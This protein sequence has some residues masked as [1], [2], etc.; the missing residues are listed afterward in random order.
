MILRRS[1]WPRRCSHA[2]SICWEGLGFGRA[3]SCLSNSLPDHS[4][5]VKGAG[6]EP[7]W[8][9]LHAPHGSGRFATP[10]APIAVPVWCPFGSDWRSANTAKPLSTWRYGSYEPRFSGS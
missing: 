3:F 1:R 8:H 4:R 2:D 7:A 5:T 6:S 10:A 9:H